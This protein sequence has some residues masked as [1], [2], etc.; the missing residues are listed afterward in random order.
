MM[1]NKNIAYLSFIIL[2]LVFSI[3][4]NQKAT[5]NNHPIDNEGETVSVIDEGKD[6]STIGEGNDIIEVEIIEEDKGIVLG[7]ERTD[8]YFPVLEGKRIAMTVNHTSFIGNTHIVD[9]LVS[10]GMDISKIF[11]PEHGF[12]GKADAGATVKDGKDSKTGLP[13]TSLYGKNKKPSPEQ[14]KDI[15]I[16]VFD[17]QDVGAR[18]YTYIST[19]HYVME[20]CAENNIPIVVLDRPN[21]NG[22]Y[23]DGPMLEDKY[24]SFVGMHD[25]PVVHGLT[26]AELARMINGE[27]WLKD[28]LK[29][30][31]IF[32]ECQ[33]YTHNTAY[34]LPI[35][36]SPNL[37]NARSIYLYPS[38]CFLEGTEANVGR[39]TT[40]QFQVVGHPKYPIK[41]FA[42]TPISRDGA[43][44]PKFEN[45]EC[46][47]IDLSQKPLEEIRAEKQI[48]LDYIVDF[49]QKMP[50]KDSY[51]LK[52]NFI[53]KLAGTA[54]LRKDILA[55]KSAAEIRASWQAGLDKYSTMRKKYLL[56]GE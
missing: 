12:R 37:P 29:A 31:L 43:K 39:G 45:K 10:A 15:D 40:T 28:D 35:K 38:L 32:V 51:F 53:D 11:A 8:A 16:V 50:N 41:D 22:H 25:I 42:Y 2:M 24:R 19:M 33:N 55:G 20:A 48:N 14:M 49:Y 6:G 26:V 44:H 13:I 7:A 36:P 47:G 9:S 46:Y 1:L 27:K 23:V 34:E 5:T 18:F 3:S 17:I 54:S 30:N 56:Y 21:P 52:N 4:C